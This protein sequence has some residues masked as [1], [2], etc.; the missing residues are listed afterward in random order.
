MTLYFVL[1]QLL[2][3]IPISFFFIF[4]PFWTRKTE[5]FGVTIP[6]EMQNHAQVRSIRM[7]YSVLMACAS[8]LIILSAFVV[9]AFFSMPEET[10]TYVS[11]TAMIALMIIGFILYVRFHFKM[12]LFKKE[13][14]NNKKHK[15]VV[16]VQTS[17][18]SEKRT[19]SNRW[20]MVSGGMI[21][22]TIYFTINNY[23]LF[24]NEIPINFNVSGEPTNWINKSHT[25][26]MFLP[27]TQLHM[28]IIFMFANTVIRTAKQQIDA[29]HPTSSVKQNILFRRRWSRF[30]IWMGTIMT[31][32]FSFIQYTHVHPVSAVFQR[33]LFTL[34]TAGLLI[35][36]IVLSFK[37]GQGGSRIRT[38]IVTTG[39]NT[40]SIRDDDEHWKLGIFYANKDDPSLFLEKR[41]GIG[42]TINLARPLVWVLFVAIIG[43][44]IGITLII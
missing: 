6:E 32:L 14:V 26:V 16:V 13:N 4:I 5:S 18:H 9:Q 21:M 38:N 24:P 33:N 43:S 11:I 37:T 35:A 28:L 8:L 3:I 15:K 1:F 10:M 25:A 19:Y 2:L 22:L 29:T 41:F 17:F 34:V 31:A 40:N 20:F 36:V 27:I 23:E 12:K 7:R 44:A 30:I 42:W 39:E